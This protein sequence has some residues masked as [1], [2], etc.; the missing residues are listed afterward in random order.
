MAVDF[1]LLE[2]QKHVEAPF[3]AREVCSV[4]SIIGGA[5]K[6]DFPAGLHK[7]LKLFL[8]FDINLNDFKFFCTFMIKF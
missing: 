8:N 4:R 1:P 3:R 2:Q 7:A 6:I 5:M